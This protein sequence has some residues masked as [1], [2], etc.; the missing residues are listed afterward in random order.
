M[1]HA[2]TARGVLNR[3]R[4]GGRGAPSGRLL[5]A[6]V[7]GVVLLA[8]GLA[9]YWLI[10]SEF[11][12]GDDEGFFDYSLNLFVAGH[13]LYNGIFS[14][15]GPFYYEVFGAVFKV[16]GHGA[17]T[18][19][20]RLINLVL[21]L[22]SSLGLGI[23]AHRLSGRLVIGVVTSASAFVLM[24]NLALDPMHPQAL[25]CALLTAMLLVTAFMVERAPRIAMHVI[26]ALAAA[27]LLTK[28]NV[29]VY[30]IVSIAF[31]AVMAGP[32]LGRRALLRAL[33]IA[34][35][36]AVGPLVMLHTL[37]TTWTE[38]YAVLVA[39]SAAALALAATPLSV[40]VAALAETS[41][42]A[43]WLLRGFG[44]CAALVLGIIFAL[45]ST[46]HA[47]FEQIVLVAS[48]QGGL[49]TIPIKLRTE[50]VWWCIA[51]TALAWILRRL[52]RTAGDPRS[53]APS[54][55]DAS[56]RLLAGIAILLSLSRTFPF[57]GTANAPFALA[58]PLAWIAALPSRRNGLEPGRH[59]VRLLI[60]SLAVLQGLLAYPVAGGEA[61]LGSLLF[62]L[63]GAV[64]V[65]DGWAEFA[66]WTVSRTSAAR[67][68]RPALGTLLV[69]LAVAFTAHHVEFEL[70]WAHAQYN[71]GTS[72]RISG[73]TWLRLPGP[74]TATYDQT[75]AA[76]RAHCKTLMS[77]PGLYSFNLWT[78]LPTPSAMT[79][80][81]PYWKTLSRSQQALVLRAA[82]SSP[83]LCLV[84]ND[85]LAD[86]YDGGASPPRVPLVAFAEDDFVPFAHFG[87]FVVETRRS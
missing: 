30:A 61:D 15:Y 68:A 12:T 58:M 39:L 24:N 19:S 55:W 11:M 21:W 6:G 27:L 5:A 2:A 38:H 59:F 3:L 87:P 76:L 36:I 57:A 16:L 82:K 20:G 44:I 66:A 74:R 64:C 63:C 47:V 1:S 9:A 23:C 37:S 32:A 45:G 31:A 13:P 79:G 48:R 86:F 7:Y 77:L 10:F 35:L 54:V 78:G 67:L 14:Q 29:G 25:V 50:V 46:P 34:A 28:I 52:G 33:V 75:V 71:S 83:G 85:A 51:A 53:R 49:L 18:D 80:E 62:L 65:A 22:A 56:L 72:L 69:A 41:G 40:S 84:R 8:C 60:P 73:A 26:G 81:Q 43:A 17:S 4:D 42:W 70:N